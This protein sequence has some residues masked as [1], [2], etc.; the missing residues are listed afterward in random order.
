MG[1]NVPYPAP[2]FN[3]NNGGQY[4]GMDMI[5]GPM[6]GLM[7]N[8][9]FPQAGIDPTYFNPAMGNPMVGQMVFSPEMM[10]GG[11]QVVGGLYP[12]Q[13]GN[14]Y[15]DAN[16]NPTMYPQYGNE[17]SGGDEWDD[18]EEDDYVSDEADGETEGR[19][20]A[21]LTKES[22]QTK[23]A[24]TLGST[25]ASITQ[26][27]EVDF[28]HQLAANSS[29]SSSSSALL[30]RGQGENNANLTGAIVPCDLEFLSK[31]DHMNE[32]EKK[33]KVIQHLTGIAEGLYPGERCERI[34][35]IVM[36]SLFGDDLERDYVSFL[37]DTRAVETKIAEVAKILPDLEDGDHENES[38]TLATPIKCER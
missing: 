27:T 10:G 34:V 12:G 25:I 20:H 38:S 13:S 6:G 3:P 30:I 15:Y 16:G 36:E 23:S 28:E 8:P 37:R 32:V 2:I 31:L 33:D 22:K 14:V 18:Y 19:N 4:S 21:S 24:T 17:E 35:D 9:M 26:D 1:R 7:M 29:N 5:P 11:P